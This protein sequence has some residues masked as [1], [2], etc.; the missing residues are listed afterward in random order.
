L[1]KGAA[2]AEALAI[3]DRIPTQETIKVGVVYV[4]PDQADEA[5]ILNN[6]LGSRSY[7]MVILLRFFFFLFSFF[8]S[9]LQ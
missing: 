5:A 2:L 9:F 6:L 1:E 7:Q 4:G 8:S 3:L